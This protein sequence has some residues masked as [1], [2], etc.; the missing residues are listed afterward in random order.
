[1]LL[2]GLSVSP[3]LRARGARLIVGIDGLRETIADQVSRITPPKPSPAC[4]GPSRGK[5]SESATAAG[6]Q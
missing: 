4:G 5:A 6:W 1:V 3:T 2:S